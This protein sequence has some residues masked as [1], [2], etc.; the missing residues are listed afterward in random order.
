MKKSISELTERFLLADRKLSILAA[1]VGFILFI[2]LGMEIG[3]RFPSACIFSLCIVLSISCIAFTTIKFL[4]PKF[5]LQRSGKQYIVYYIILSLV[6]IRI[7]AGITEFLLSD[8]LKIMTTKL[9]IMTIDEVVLE[10]AQ[11]FILFFFAFTICNVI[12]FRG[13]IKDDAANKEKLTS[14]MNSMEM[15]ALKSQ[16]NTHFLHN[17]LNNIYSMIYFGDKD[18]AAKY[19]TKLSQMLR[20]VLDDCEANKVPISKEISYIRNYIDFQKARF[21]TERDIIFKYAQNDD[22]EILIPPMLFQP[23]IENCF[24]HCPLQ[25]DGNFIHVDIAVE[26]KQIKFISEN[27]KHA[28]RQPAERNGGGIGV[29]NLESRLSILFKDN[30]SLNISDEGNIY[31]TELIINL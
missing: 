9:K 21:E 24:K 6:F 28:I 22:G 23:L 8:V 20:Y 31:R 29:K 27:T 17:A 7:V 2:G 19:V 25:N 18:N 3:L 30:Y 15:R 10:P 11:Y 4:I 12:F 13:K 5:L 14:E 26:R 16:I 1:V